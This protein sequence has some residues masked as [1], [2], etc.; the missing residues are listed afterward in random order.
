M[1][2]LA[3]LTYAANIYP[4]F[5]RWS[6]LLPF[7][8]YRIDSLILDPLTCY[9][10]VGTRKSLIKQRNPTLGETPVH[11]TDASVYVT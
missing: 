4:R 9:S 10:C 7:S 6:S 1:V 2:L 3:G 11:N 5:P 8:I